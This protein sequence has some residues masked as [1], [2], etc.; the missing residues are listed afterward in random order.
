MSLY[1]YL[2]SIIGSWWHDRDPPKLPGPGFGIGGGLRPKGSRPR[3]AEDH[4][5][6]LLRQARH[7]MAHDA[8]GRL[9]LDD[10]RSQRRVHPVKN[11][12]FFF[13]WEFGFLPRTSPW[14]KRFRGWVRCASSTLVHVPRQ[15]QQGFGPRPVPPLKLGNWLI[16]RFKPSMGLNPKPSSH[17]LSLA[18]PPTPSAWSPVYFSLESFGVCKILCKQI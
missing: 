5:E 3:L 2:S 12:F 11:L 1:F 10:R 15:P 13:F 6:G 17:P 9:D 14:V 7:W 8:E 16:H 4:Q 18:C